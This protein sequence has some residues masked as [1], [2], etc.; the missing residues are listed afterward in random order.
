MDIFVT[1]TSKPLI[2]V[3]IIAYN[4]AREI[5]RTVTSFLDDYQDHISA[6]E[7]EIIVME[8][9][10][11]KP[12]PKSIIANWP[13]NVRYINVTDPHPSPARALNQGV[14][15]ARGKWVCPVIDGARMITS[16]FLWKAKCLMAAHDNPVVATIGRHLGAKPQQEN[17]LDGYNQAT[18][19]KLLESINWPHEP[20]R[21]FDISSLGASA[22]GS[23]INPIAESNVLILKKSFYQ[24]IGGYDEQFDL[25]GGGIV[26]LDF[27]KRV[28]D[29]KNSRYFL[30]IDEASFHQYH[31]GVT[32][33]RSVSLPSIEDKSRSTWNVYATQYE[34]I[35]G[36]P[37]SKPLAKPFIF[38]HMCDDVRRELL[39]SAENILS[40]EK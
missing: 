1:D 37:Y 9:G 13:A 32:T 40:E 28:I 38:G 12:V 8:N 27:F 3:I 34:K 2:S 15:I 36:K 23:W 24:E 29:H 26:N 17:V 35:R 25:P 21:L 4:M 19:D 11:D 10:S 6:D 31:G 5:P 16:G 7:I 39:K 22:K 14:E 18:E 20:A 33:S 30:L